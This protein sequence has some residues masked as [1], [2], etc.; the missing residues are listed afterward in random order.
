MNP[1]VLLV[2]SA[3]AVDELVR[4]AVAD[5]TAKELER[6]A[7]AVPALQ[8]DPVNTKHVLMTAE[9]SA[10]LLGGVTTKPMDYGGGH[11]L[12]CHRP[13]G[14]ALFF[15]EEVEARVSGS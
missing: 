12:P 3:S 6:H 10:H 9:V 4:N 8:A 11:G 14:T 5:T 2:L 13:A 1:D 7:N 15:R